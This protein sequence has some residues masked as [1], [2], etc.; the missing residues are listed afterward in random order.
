MDIQTTATKMFLK[1]DEEKRERV[2]AA[3]INEFADKN[4]NNASMNV[5]VKAA[6]ISKGALFKYFRSK[7]GLFGFVYKMALGR[8]K[9]YLKQVRDESEAE[10]FFMR[11]EKVM[12]AGLDFIC[13]HPGLAAIYYRIVFTGDSPYK[14]EIVAEVHRESLAFIKS[15]IQKGIERGELRSDLDPEL[16]SFMVEAVVD[17]F[18]HA[19][20]AQFRGQLGSENRLSHMET[21]GEIEGILKMLKCGMTPSVLTERQV[22]K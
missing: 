11:L 16:S 21:N 1:L 4:Y 17:R 5:V 10:D 14:R 19:H 12:L 20:H 8:V 2:L 3:A 22:I 6:G 7:A 13:A 15:L 18:V 9:D